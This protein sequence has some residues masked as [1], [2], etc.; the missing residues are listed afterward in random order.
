[1]VSTFFRDPQALSSAL[2]VLG[3]LHT[4]AFGFLN[5]IETLDSASNYYVEQ[6]STALKYHF[7]FDVLKPQMSFNV[8]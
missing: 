5:R 8:Y 1:M 2:T 7:R 6:Y 4:Q 3:T